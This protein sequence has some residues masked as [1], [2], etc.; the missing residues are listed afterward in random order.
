MFS[1]FITKTTKAKIYKVLSVIFI[2][3]DEG[4]VTTLKR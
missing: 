1:F 2:A 4:A 3:S